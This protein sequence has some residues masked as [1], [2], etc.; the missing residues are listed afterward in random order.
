MYILSFIIYLCCCFWLDG[1]FVTPWNTCSD[2]TDVQ[3][4]AENG[5]LRALHR[6][7]LAPHAPVEP[8]TVRF[9]DLVVSVLAAISAAE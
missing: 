9:V 5:A 3:T 4:L 7:L 8:S 6:H 1:W 2:V